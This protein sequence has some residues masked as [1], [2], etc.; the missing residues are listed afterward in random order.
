MSTAVG[1]P[2]VDERH[3][4]LSRL[5]YRTL[6]EQAKQSPLSDFDRQRLLDACEHV[7]YRLAEQPFENPAFGRLTSR[8]LYREVQGSFA[9]SDRPMLF[10]SIR[11]MVDLADELLE[12][13]R[14]EDERQCIALN[15]FGEPCRRE[16]RAGSEYCPSHRHLELGL[17]EPDAVALISSA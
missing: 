8:W 6:A 7:V 3:Y 15:R 10:I 13:V 11:R 1:E 2:A 17:A 12:T 4:A 5:L 14:R 9:L 16:A